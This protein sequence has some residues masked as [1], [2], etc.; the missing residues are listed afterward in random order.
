MNRYTHGGNLYKAARETGG[1]DFL[2]FSANINPLGLPP[3]VLAAL[4]A[5]LPAVV[6]YPDPEAVALRESIVAHYRLQPESLVL[7]NGAAELFYLLCLVKRPK[8]VLVCPP[9][10]SEYERAALAAGAAVQLVPLQASP[11]YNVDWPALQDAIADNSLV[12]LGHPNNP[13]GNLLDMSALQRFLAATIAK[14]CLVVVDESFLDFVDADG[15]RSCQSWVQQYPH[16]VAVRSLTKVFAIPGLR[17]GFGVMQN[18]LAATLNLAKDQWNVNVLA[19]LAG[20]AAFSDPSYLAKT[21][22]QV[23]VWRQQLLDGLAAIPSVRAT[24]SVANFLLLDMEATGKTAAWWRQAF[25]ARR[26]LVRDCSNYAALSP[27]HIRIAVR[28]DAENKQ[29]LTAL[30]AL[31]EEI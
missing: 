1:A 9:A 2:D 30:H 26:I 22:A 16:L 24:P 5:S 21:R 31:L 19:Q 25:F 7:G 4:Q 15:S 29:F 17:L 10:F 3:A 20:A 6:H 13:T 8:T 12:F 23:P 18:S 11:A 14:N 27:Y 28:T